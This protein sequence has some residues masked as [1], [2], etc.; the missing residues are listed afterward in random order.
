MLKSIVHFSIVHRW[1]VLLGI[2]ALCG[3][4]IYHFKQFSIDA[5]PD[6]TNIQVQVNTEAP[7][8]SPLEI[9]QR[10]TY[11][12]E[13]GLAG[14][15]KLDYTRSISRYGL[16]QVTVVFQEKT[17]IYFARQLITERLQQLKTELPPNIEPTLGPIA[18]GLGEIF[19]YV[20]EA[21]PG[22]KKSDGTSYTPMDLRTLQDW[23]IRPQLRNIK[24][25]IEVN[26]IGGYEKQLH[27]L[28]DLNKLLAY[29]LT[30]SE[31][32][33]ALEKNNNNIGAGYIEKN[34]EQYLIRVPGQVKNIED[35]KNIPIANRDEI[36]IKISDISTVELGYPLRTGAATQNAN[37]IV[38]GTVMMLIGENSKEVA[39]SVAN[40]LK[41][42]NQNLPKGVVAKEVYNRKFLVDKTIATV[43]KNLVEGA[44]LVIVILSLLLGNIRAALITAAVIPI[45]MLMTITGMVANKVSGNLMSLGALDFGLIVDGAVIIVENCLRRISAAQKERAIPLSKEERF[46]LVSSA[47]AEVIKPSIFGIIIIT[48][49]YL[50]IFSLTG[51]EGKMFH[52]MAFTVV[53]ALISS[54][55]LCLTFVP[56]SVAL[57]MNGRVS[58]EENIIIRKFKTL[59]SPI[60]KWTLKYP[61]AIIASSLLIVII[62]IFTFLSLGREF[63]P[64]LEEGDI[65]LHAMRI[66]GTSLSQS[67]QMQAQVETAIQKIPEVKE[68][69]AKI[70]TPDIATDPM[71]PNVADTYV[72]L[73]PRA[74][75]LNPK[76][77]QADLV[78]EIEAALK[79]VPGNNYEFSQPIQMRFNELI[80]GVRSDLAVKIF[81]DDPEILSQLANEVESLLKVTQGAKDIKIEQTTGL[82][83]LNITPNQMALK[84]FGL[85]LATV[86]D[87]VSTAMNGKVAGKIFEGDKR[88]DLIVKLPDYLRSDLNALELLTIPLPYKTDTNQPDRIPLKEVADITISYGPNQISRENGKRK[89]IVSA[90]VRDRDLG[91]FVKEVQSLAKSNIKLPTGYWIEYGGTFEQL[92]SAQNRLM[93]VVPIALLLVFILLFVA[94]DSVLISLIIFTGV[95]L[96]LT[97]GV[98]GLWLRNMPFSISAGVGFIALSGIAVLNGL[99]M[100]AFIKKL[101][102]QGYTLDEA[103][104][105]GA[106][107]RTRAILMTALVASLGFLPMA[108]NVGAGSEIQKPLAT[109]VIGGIVSSTILTL[110]VLPAIYKIFNKKITFSP[111]EKKLIA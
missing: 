40:K 49:V 1:L 43:T 35:I 55:I 109:V 101:Q 60:L 97:G 11:P 48:V 92:I 52:P 70:G 41:Q 27:I 110:L 32:I 18:T 46:H 3:L 73:K 14:L 26:T 105:E 5:V 108:I 62:S 44:M 86:Q 84:Q 22:A 53:I 38:L 83:L 90:N 19:M 61:L 103:I 93:I 20:V 107:T 67:I 9:E 6:I 30:I 16:S 24:G 4:G 25:V 82:P 78:K 76:K 59:Y 79:E 8:Y 29:D 95:P 50:P 37:E 17:D 15:P 54:L 2:L 7:G 89:I 65:A 36:T 12:I 63:M 98:A 64:N 47:S 111:K 96:A 28:P 81:G 42:I 99:V 94:F 66:P 104:I 69:F 51:I 33:A 21:Q 31:V 100:V 77:T 68:T 13:T 80:S 85:D 45:S 102:A 57:F 72:M 88:F 58:E 56:A 75:W 23:V 39:T 71:P 74:Q 87:V 91:S 106:L 10:I 34:G